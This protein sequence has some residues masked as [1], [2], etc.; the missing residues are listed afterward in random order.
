[1][2]YIQGYVQVLPEM[3]GSALVSCFAFESG[4]K[5]EEVDMVASSTVGFRGVLDG[6]AWKWGISRMTGGHQL[7]QVPKLRKIQRKG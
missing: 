4:F 7:P 1:M 6:K 2:F 3:P 5:G